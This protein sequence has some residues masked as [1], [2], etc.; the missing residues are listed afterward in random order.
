MKFKCTIKE[1][2]RDYLTEEEITLL[3]EKEID[4]DR[5][6]QVRDIFVFCCYTLL[7]YA[8]VHKLTP[9]QIGRGWMGN[10]GNSP[11]APK[12]KQPLTFLYSP[13][14]LHWWINTKITRKL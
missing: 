14:P 11:T 1:T 3:Q 6:A 9:N 13:L 12:P 2:K 7:A 8:D 5:L 4:I 10:T